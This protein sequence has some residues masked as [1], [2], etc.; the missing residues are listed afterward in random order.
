MLAFFYIYFLY[1]YMYIILHVHCLLSQKTKLNIRMVMTYSKIKDQQGKATH[2]A[3]G[4]LKGKMNN[5]SLSPFTPESLVLRYGFGSPVQR[6]RT[7]LHSQAEY[8]A[9]WILTEFLDGVHL[10]IITVI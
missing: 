10:Y 7:N 3:R 5:I 9:Y 2:P 4:Q 1:R 8:G 6:Q